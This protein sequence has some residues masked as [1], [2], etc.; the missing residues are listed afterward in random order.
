[1][2]SGS[3]PFC[4]LAISQDERAIAALRRDVTA[5]RLLAQAAIAELALRTSESDRLRRQLSDMR[6]ELRL[7]MGVT[8]YVAVET[9]TAWE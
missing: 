4:R 8:P 2:C 6:E 1:M 9:L 3:C 7:R 5:Y